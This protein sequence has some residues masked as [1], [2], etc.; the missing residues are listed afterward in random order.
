MHLLPFCVFALASLLGSLCLA[1]PYPL[2]D[3]NAIGSPIM[4]VKLF[5]ELFD[6]PL[7]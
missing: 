3:G 1:L 7:I 2:D 5:R 6:V 4:K